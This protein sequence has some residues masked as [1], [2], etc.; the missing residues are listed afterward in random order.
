M[1]AYNISIEANGLSTVIDW[2]NA[3][4]WQETHKNEIDQAERIS[5]I[6]KTGVELPVV[7]CQLD[8]GHQCRVFSRV[9]GQIQ[10]NIDNRVRLYCIGE[11]EKPLWIYPSG[12]IEQAKEPSMVN[13]WLLQN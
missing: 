4:N 1:I 12:A 10:N 2:G 11:A 8:E 3:P 5:L 9:Y 6:P 13:L 7:T